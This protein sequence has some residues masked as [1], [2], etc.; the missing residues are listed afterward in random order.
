MDCDSYSEL[1]DVIKAMKDAGVSGVIVFK[2][3]CM[4]TDTKETYPDMILSSSS[5]ASV[6]SALLGNVV[7]QAGVTKVV[8]GCSCEDFPEC[9]HD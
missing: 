5:D 6:I 9:G 4:D 2:P 1:I 7:P 8:Q 3:D